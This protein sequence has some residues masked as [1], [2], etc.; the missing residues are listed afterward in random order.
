MLNGG[1]HG[2]DDRLA[3]SHPAVWYP[4]AAG[5]LDWNEMDGVF[6]LARPDRDHV[7]NQ[8]GVVLLELA[9]GR[10]TVDEMVEIVRQAFRLEDAPEREVREF[11]DRAR[12]AGLVE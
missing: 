11:L 10:H 3:G 2:A 6:L 1:D 5:P 8:T 4:R 9:N 7:V 12:E